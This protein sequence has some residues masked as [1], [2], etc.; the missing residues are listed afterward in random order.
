MENRRFAVLA[1]LGCLAAVLIGTVVAI[2]LLVGPITTGLSRLTQAT[3]PGTVSTVAQPTQQTVAALPTMTAMPSQPG[4][5][6]AQTG[7]EPSN[8]A[9]GSLAPLYQA[10][11][12]GV[13]NV[14]VYI[15][16]GGMTGQGA[17]SG[18]LIDTEGHIVTNDHVVA[19]AEAVTVVFH[20]GTEVHAD[21][22]GTDPDS[23]LAVI[24]A[25]S[26]PDGAHPA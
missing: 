20:D 7:M 17:G 8:V 26:V 21:I 3:G 23:D 4:E 10:V 11:N 13:V 6:P 19:Q 24:K 18:F 15:A 9:T 14:R 5:N 25:E 2:A 16:R 1:G 22:V 12:P